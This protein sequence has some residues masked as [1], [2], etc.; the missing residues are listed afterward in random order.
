M[1]IPLRLAIT[2]AVD[3]EDEAQQG[4][5]EAEQPWSI[6]LAGR[7]LCML[8]EGAAAQHPGAAGGN[9]ALLQCQ[10]EKEEGDIKGAE[11]DSVAALSVAQLQAGSASPWQPYLQV[12]RGPSQTL[13]RGRPGCL[14]GVG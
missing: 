8:A 3:E 11:T 7:L 4:S 14:P 12:R 5:R 13:V 2:D 9:A 10:L 1:R 6:R